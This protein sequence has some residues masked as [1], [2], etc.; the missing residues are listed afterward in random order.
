MAGVQHKDRTIMEIR[1]A[2][3]SD[4]FMCVRGGADHDHVHI[5]NGLIDHGRTDLRKAFTFKLTRNNDSAQLIQAGDLRLVMVIQCHII[6]LACQIGRHGLAAG[7]G[8]NNRK[9]QLVH[10]A[11]LICKFVLI[12]ERLFI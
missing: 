11:L 2:Q 1:R 3:I 10:T 8:A 12:S 4:L 9:F 7:A 5:L 6:I